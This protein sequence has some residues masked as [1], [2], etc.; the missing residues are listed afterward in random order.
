MIV[1]VDVQL[2]SPFKEN[3]SERR[4]MSVAEGRWT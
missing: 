4:P 1:F 2:G 3:V